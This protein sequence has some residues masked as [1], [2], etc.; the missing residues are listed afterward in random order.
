MSTITIQQ[1]IISAETAAA[2]SLNRYVDEMCEMEETKEGF[3]LFET[4][5]IIF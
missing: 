5:F 2:D 3:N 1:A 4:I